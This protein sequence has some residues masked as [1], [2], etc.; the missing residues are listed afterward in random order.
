MKYL[1]YLGL[2]VFLFSPLQ[3]V[4][5]T[6]IANHGATITI[7]E[8]AIVDID[9]E[10]AANFQ[11][12]SSG[13]F[14]G[15]IILGGKLFLEGDFTNNV[16]GSPLF[17]ITSATSEVVF[18]GTLPQAINGTGDLIF[19]RI[20]IANTEM[21]LENPI[22]I[23]DELLLNESVI[24]LGNNDLWLGENAVVS[25]VTP[26][27]ATNMIVADSEGKLHKDFE[28]DDFFTFPVGDNTGTPEYSPVEL[29]LMATGYS[30]ANVAVNLRNEKHPQNAATTDY[31]NRYWTV[32][33]SGL[34]APSYNIALL[35]TPADVAGT[36]SNIY[37]GLFA[38]TVWTLLSQ[39]G[40]GQISADALTEFG[41]FT[42][43]EYNVIVPV[44]TIAENDILI[45]SY[46][47]EITVQL[48][49]NTKPSESR[50]AVY[51][52]HGRTIANRQP[53]D[54]QTTFQLQ[55]A[56]GIY[57]VKVVTNS[58]VYSQKLTIHTE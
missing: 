54:L 40:L 4:A 50:I 22:E 44:G 30:Q 55:A 17:V 12:L 46:E 47:N 2:F 35:Y 9:G 43:S 45:Y 41:D 8:G 37:G 27:S 14:A 31:L 23:S 39:A 7:E 32:T 57:I 52:M 49:E 36:E 13:A 58:S 3:L 19:S 6:G 51:D 15:Q 5:Q 16:S 26:F 34:T 24:Y 18:D 10:A 25:A 29:D 11:N 38:N 21:L 53:T 28:Q 48:P 33:A 20:E 42:G 1:L 56:S